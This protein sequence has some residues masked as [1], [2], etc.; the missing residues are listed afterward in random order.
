M[1]SEHSAAEQGH[2]INSPE[3]ST[4]RLDLLSQRFS[5]AEIQCLSRLQLRHR[6]SP[7]KLDLPVDPCRLSFAR[8]LF[9]HGRLTEEM[10]R[11]D[12]ALPHVAPPWEEQASCAPGGQG[13]M[14]DA[15]QDPS[16]GRVGGAPEL[17][18][19][20]RK[21]SNAWR[22]ALSRALSRMRK[23]VARV[24][25]ISSEAGGMAPPRD[26]AGPWTLDGRPCGSERPFD[27][28][29]GWIHSREGWWW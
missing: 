15:T 23:A 24:G 29:L 6:T 9:E 25:D 27:P 22:L 17:E 7:D 10:D 16:D 1:H 21:L 19:G 11:D 12:V 4:P 2:Q 26:E 18:S 28:R 20:C 14:P 13:G 3:G 5:E 8:W